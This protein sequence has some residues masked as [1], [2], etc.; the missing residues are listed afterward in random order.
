M[1]RIAKD[2]DLS[3]KLD[4]DYP[5]EL[6]NIAKSFNELTQI[7]K[8]IVDGAKLN[9]NEN[10]SVSHELSKVSL[11]VGNRVEESVRVI[12]STKEEADEVSERI[13]NAIGEAK[14]NKSKIIEANKLLIKSRNDL[15]KL[16]DRIE[17]S[18]QSE[19]EI[20]IKIQALADDTEQIKSVLEVI[21]DIADQTNLLALNAAIEA[22]RAGEHGKGFAV[23]ADEVRKLAERT[24]KSLIEINSTVSIV[25]Q[26]IGEASEYMNANSNDINELVDIS[27]RVQEEMGEVASTV[28]EVTELNDNVEEFESIG[29]TIDKITQSINEI[30]SI[31]AKNLRSVEDIASAA[32][33]LSRLTEKL[34]QKLEQIKT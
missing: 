20:S 6:S 29:D 2:R 25:V 34:A 10:S 8:D 33:H 23:V 28:K 3:I 14:E 22:A 4:G 30:D 16:V 32:E 11:E 31:S 9:S 5:K 24:Q 15:M 18:A 17:N 19:N 27:I 26:A 7:F 12:N 13:C 1:K 21:S